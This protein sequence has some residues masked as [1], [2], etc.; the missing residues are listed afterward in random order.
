M[1]EPRAWT[2]DLRKGFVTVRNDSDTPTQENAPGL[3]QP[4][5]ETYAYDPAGNM[6]TLQHKSWK[7]NDWQT[8]WSRNFGMGE[9]TPE[10]WAESWPEH[11]QADW[12]AA[13]GNQLT[14]VED[15]RSGIA[16]KPVVRQTHW[17]DDNG[18]LI[19]EKESRYFEWDHSDQ[20]RLFREQ[21]GEGEPSVVA[22]YLYDAAGQRVKKLVWK[23]ETHC[24]VTVYVD[25]VSELH[26]LVTAEGTKEN[27]TLHVMDDQ[28]RVALVRVGKPWDDRN[29]GP[30]VQ[31]HLGDHLGSSAVV[32]NGEGDWINRE[33]FL[34]YGETSFGS[35]KWKRYRYTGKERDEE[36][37]LYYHGA[38]YY[39]PWLAR[40]MSCDP[41]EEIQS[42]YRYG[43]NNPLIY[44]D[45]DGKEPKLG[46]LA[47]FQ[48]IKQEIKVS[49]TQAKNEV[50]NTE[51]KLQKT[52]PFKIL[53]KLSKYEKQKIQLETM[54]EHFSGNRRYK[55]DKNNKIVDTKGSKNVKRYIFTEKY[56]WLDLHHL[57]K[58]AIYTMKY[59]PLISS[60]LVTNSEHVQA[61]T[62]PASAY[63]YE[64]LPS[65]LAGIHF[66]KYLTNQANADVA[67]A[68]TE[69]IELASPKQP[70][71][72]PNFLFIPHM[73]S[74][75]TIK[76]S[77]TNPIE[78]NQLAFKSHDSYKKLSSADQQRILDAHWQLEPLQMK[79]FMNAFSQRINNF[80]KVLSK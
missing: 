25:G 28:Q 8:S 17:F 58:F 18:N 32:V 79:L 55:R 51:K 24:E 27:N 33:E 23:G 62:Q 47:S 40:W 29:V 63:S 45:L 65:N 31:Y 39:A 6:V 54:S 9:M 19:R 14:H 11:V 48:D 69:F 34:P 44:S 67:L 43:N 68:L 2:D 59:T 75:P 52:V 70:F 42:R 66:Y 64:D 13:P 73:V 35:F 26:R 77:T 16:S 22:Q 5:K 38:R 7:N 21:A 53:Q 72:A 56:G 3:T 30:S 20:L 80:L 10:E 57:L 50:K 12:S 49:A 4:Y 46:Q 41:L 61:M 15:R 60:S 37:G 1:G 74:H 76:N 71:E 78:G 36:S